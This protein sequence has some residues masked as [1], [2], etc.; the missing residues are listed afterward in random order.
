LMVRS[1]SASLGVP[2]GQFE[3][4]AKLSQKAQARG[5]VNQRVVMQPTA[6]RFPEGSS[7]MGGNSRISEPMPRSAPARSMG[8]GAPASHASAGGAPHK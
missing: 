4:M 7:R 8:G 6:A 5:V 2:R 3:N 1:N